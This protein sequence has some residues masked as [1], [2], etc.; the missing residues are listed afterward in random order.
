MIQ[1][2][3]T[4][5]SSGNYI[6]IDNKMNFDELIYSEYNAQITSPFVKNSSAN[7]KMAFW[8]QIK[9]NLISIILNLTIINFILI[10]GLF[11]R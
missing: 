6:F 7:C 4:G 11:K 1:D 5:F 2:H 8:Y 10:N 9:G 3:T